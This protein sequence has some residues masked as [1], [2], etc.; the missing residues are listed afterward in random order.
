MVIN[1]RIAERFSFD[2]TRVVCRFYNLHVVNNVCGVF[3]VTGFCV[4]ALR[5]WAELHVLGGFWPLVSDPLHN[6]K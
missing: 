6:N 4:C 1:R 3:D 5:V 2:T